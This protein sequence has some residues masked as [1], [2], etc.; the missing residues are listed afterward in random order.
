M[1]G[2][3]A[4]SVGAADAE[5]A[6]KDSDAE[7]ADHRLQAVGA[8]GL[9]LAH[10]GQHDEHESERVEGAC[11]ALVQLGAK[12]RDC[13]VDGV[14]RVGAQ[15]LVGV[16]LARPHDRGLIAALLELVASTT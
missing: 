4:T 3:T 11:K 5:H 15:Q 13:L 6:R 12:R 7:G 10:E 16:A 1:A 2:R 14:L 9:G 8:G